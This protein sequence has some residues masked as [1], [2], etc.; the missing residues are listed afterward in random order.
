MNYR[1]LP[2]PTLILSLLLILTMG[3]TDRMLDRGSTLDPSGES[4]VSV[5]LSVPDAVSK[6]RAALSPEAER[7]VNHLH[8]YIFDDKG[9]LELHKEYA[10][11]DLYQAAA[12]LST[13][14]NESDPVVPSSKGLLLNGIELSHGKKT[15]VA[16]ANHSAELNEYDGGALGLDK[17][18]TLADLE[19]AV[20]MLAQPYSIYRQLG[21]MF[22]TAFQ[23][24]SITDGTKRV[25][26]PLRRLDAKVTLNILPSQSSTQGTKVSF[27]PLSYRVVNV[28][29]KSHLR[30]LSPESKGNDADAAS[31]TS[32]GDYFTTDFLD[33]DVTTS[34][35]D[36]VTATATFYIPENRKLP[37]R[38]ITATGR[39][40]YK[41][42]SKQLKTPLGPEAAL[43]DGKP[44]VSNGDFEYAPKYATYVEIKGIYLASEGSRAPQHNRTTLTL[45]VP[46]GYTDAADPIN[47]YRVERNVHY[48]YN[49][50][51]NG[52]EDVIVEAKS[53]KDNEQEPAPDTEGMVIKSDIFFKADAH[54]EQF[55]IHFN[56]KQLNLDEEGKVR[57]ISFLISTPFDDN[58]IVSY[59]AEE[60]VQLKANGF[61]PIDKEKRADTSWLQFYIHPNSDHSNKTIRYS[62]TGANLLTLEQ[63]LYCVSLDNAEGSPTYPYM[64]DQKGNAKVTVFLDEYFYDHT[65]AV[66]STDAGP[67]DKDLWKRFCNQ[68]D[69]AFALLVDDG[70]QISPDGRSRLNEALFG[71]RQ[72]S[73]QTFFSSDA[74]G[75]VHIWGVES[76]DETPDRDWMVTPTTSLASYYNEFFSNGWSNTWTLM[77]QR[78][79]K[80]EKKRLPHP[81][82]VD[83][84]YKLWNIMTDLTNDGRVTLNPKRVQNSTDAG[85]DKTANYAIFSPFTR[86]RDT[87]RDGY[88]QAREIKWYIPSP[89]AMYLIFA[90]EH[91][92]PT[93]ARIYG[94][95]G[96]IPTAFFSS[97]RYNGTDNTLVY[98]S[99]PTVF[100]S[101][102]GSICPLYDFHEENF[103]NGI[104][105]GKGLI[106]PPG[107][108]TRFSSIRLIR[109]LGVL[110]TSPNYEDSYHLSPSLIKG[111]ICKSLNP[112]SAL[113]E[114]RKLRADH[115]DPRIV[116]HRRVRY[117][118]PIHDENSDAN[119]IYYKGFQVARGLVK[120]DDPNRKNGLDGFYYA[121]WDKLVSDI[122][123]GKDPCANYYENPDKSDL[124]TWR[125]P[126]LAEMQ[127]M[128][129][130]LFDWDYSE[131]KDVY[132][133]DFPRNQV[134]DAPLPLPTEGNWFHTITR[135]SIQNNTPAGVPLGSYLLFS[136]GYLRYVST[137]DTRYAR[138]GKSTTRTVAEAKAYIRCVRDLE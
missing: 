112:G 41:L 125:L 114:I 82:R 35:T 96:K 69:R 63:F 42:R 25:D 34:Q 70:G 62:D 23:E 116:R 33:F 31:A 46:L 100:V 53:D 12:D 133:K 52:V 65:P 101:S 32:A 80:W 7:L 103:G 74:G 135:S 57:S 78:V 89:G 15:F 88:V 111:E 105:D 123:R 16:I 118:L 14:Y 102:T 68:P 106:P 37:T 48:T 85:S 43:S 10:E 131:A 27:E 50:R 81:Y 71:I 137:T 99:N 26:L 36:D 129:V 126:N 87:N 108:R 40:G 97:H 86:N 124:G 13:K 38:K 120:T 136:N 54:Y 22:M 117:Q 134:L 8:L 60:L 84:A 17:I 138:E 64:F 115:L 79:Q 44:S 109:D 66:G 92:L 91:V 132:G 72:N 59:T 2:I 51:V 61:K 29:I 3:C 128:S 121:S 73:I 119:R 39:E 130:N 11:A 77:A 107:D 93:S 6:M 67:L 24:I 113:T 56:R 127:M 18:K 5:S 95:G 76:V 90:G 47:D 83:G 9:D 75:K 19:K 55:V 1:T 45:K 21:H 28:P 58:R 94:H 110:E 30:E 98:S 122:R 4:K 104:G 20:V 49:I